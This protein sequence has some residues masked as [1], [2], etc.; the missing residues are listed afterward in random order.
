MKKYLYI[1]LAAAALTSCSSDETL[2]I[3]KEAIA[4][5][6]A[7]VENSTRA[8]EAADPS[9][10]AK[11]PITS[12]R[13]YGTV[14]NINIYNAVNVTKGDKNYNEA[15]NCPVT[16]Y[17]VDGADYKF[18]AVV[19]NITVDGTTITVNNGTVAL[20][21]TNNMPT[22]IQYTADGTTDLLYAEVTREDVG[23]ADKGLVAFTFNHL[24]AKAKFTVTN[25][26]DHTKV[27][28]GTAYTYD[29][30]NLQITNTYASGTY[31][32]DNTWANLGS[33]TPTTF[34]D[35][36]DLTHTTAQVCDAEKL[37]IP[38]LTSVTVSF[39]YDIKL[40]GTVIY[41]TPSAITKTVAIP[42]EI[43]E[44]K[45]QANNA[46]NFTLS[47]G[48]NTPIQFTVTKAPEWAATKDVTVPAEQQ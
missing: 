22:S 17:W 48:L 36:T 39:E 27:Q 23:D 47:V 4:F 16:Q 45:I 11:T 31:N 46:Y 33:A 21:N 41:T 1:A 2:D 34:G 42:N 6:D 24:L 35:I 28:A 3:Q 19:N 38:G 32:V 13:L 43:T 9:Y 44:G 30:K 20:N 37:L 7:F 29:I 15:W 14:N 8:T 10:G 5:G 26:T 18:A 40:N 12:F 25:T